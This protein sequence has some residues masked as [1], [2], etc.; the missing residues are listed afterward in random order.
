MARRGRVQMYDRRRC[1]AK[2]SPAPRSRANA[3]VNRVQ[4]VLNTAIYITTVSYA[5]SII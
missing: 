1:G 5:L 3:D 2:H 4:T